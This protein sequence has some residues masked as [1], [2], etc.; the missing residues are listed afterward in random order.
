MNLIEA[1]RAALLEHLAELKPS[2]QDNLTDLERHIRAGGTLASYIAGWKNDRDARALAGKPS[3]EL[4]DRVLAA[5]VEPYGTVRDYLTQLLAML[6]AG[7][8]DATYGMTGNSDWQYD[9]YDALCRD[10]LIPGW[11]DGYGMD[12]DAEVK[13]SNLLFAAMAHMTGGKVE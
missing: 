12:R 11:R 8:A 13:A 4:L 6:W 3:P 5:R 7:R 10:G 2:E 9:V 1:E